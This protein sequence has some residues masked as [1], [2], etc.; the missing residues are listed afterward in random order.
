MVY[1]SYSNEANAT[2]SAAAAPSGLTATGN[3]TGIAL[4]WTDNTGDETGFYVERKTGPTG[5]YAQIGTVAANTTTFTDPAVQRYTTYYYRVRAYASQGGYTSYSNEASGTQSAGTA[6]SGLSV[7]TAGTL[8]LVLSWTDNTPDETNFA[9]ERKAGTGG[10]YAQIGTVSANVATYA[11]LTV[12]AG[13]AYYYRV[14]AYNN[15][16][17]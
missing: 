16:D 8:G 11:D 12:A 2:Q 1:T 3:P 5:T 13:T 15:S 6:P 4:T 14:R 17:P 10:T 7:A 9:I